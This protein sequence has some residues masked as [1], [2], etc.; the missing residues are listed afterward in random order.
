MMFKGFFVFHC[1][2]CRKSKANLISP[3]LIGIRYRTVF[4]QLQIFIIISKQIYYGLEYGLFNFLAVPVPHLQTNH[5]QW[6]E[7]SGQV[8]VLYLYRNKLKKMKTFQASLVE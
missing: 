6:R 5:S 4:V 3:A 7:R 1:G 2:F 8:A